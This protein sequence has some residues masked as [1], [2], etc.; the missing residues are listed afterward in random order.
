MGKKKFQY[1][2]NILYWL[3]LRLLESCHNWNLNRAPKQCP[4]IKMGIPGTLE[5]SSPAITETATRWQQGNTKQFF[6]PNSHALPPSTLQ[7]YWAT[8]SPLTFI[9]CHSKPPHHRICSSLGP[10]TLSLPTVLTLQEWVHIQ[11]CETISNS[12]LINLRPAMSSIQTWI[13]H[14][15]TEIFGLHAYVSYKIRPMSFLSVYVQILEQCLAD[16]TELLSGCILC[17]ATLHIS[18]L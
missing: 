12:S 14:S 3:Y 2:W 10:N 7:K 4:W 11:L 16:S 1:A 13:I 5:N 18:C 15:H 17:S 6:N 9:T 8:S